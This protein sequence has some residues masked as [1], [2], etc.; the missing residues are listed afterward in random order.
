MKRFILVSLC[1]IAAT[2]PVQTAYSWYSDCNATSSRDTSFNSP[3]SAF[4][5]AGEQYCGMVLF[6]IKKEKD[7]PAEADLLKGHFDE[8]LKEAPKKPSNEIKE[9]EK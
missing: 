1:L 2:L 5:S 8:V 7:K 3:G 6:R 9:E 4:P